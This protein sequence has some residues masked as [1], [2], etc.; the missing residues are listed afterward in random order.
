C[1]QF[2][3]LVKRS[4]ICAFREPSVFAVK[5]IQHIVLGFVVGSVFYKLPYDVEGA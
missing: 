1:R 4:I 2:C 3:A 5:L